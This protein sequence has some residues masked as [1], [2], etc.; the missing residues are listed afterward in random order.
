[1]T[2]Y[3]KS[4]PNWN[5]SQGPRIFP[6]LNPSEDLAYILGVLKG[7]GYVTKNGYQYNVCLQ[8][9]S[10][11]FVSSFE[12]SL[13]NIGLHPCKIYHDRRGIYHSVACSLQFVEFYKNLSMSRLKELIAGY[14]SHFIK[15][16]YESEGTLFIRGQTANFELNIANSNLELLKIVSRYLFYKNIRNSI[17]KRGKTINDLQMYR[18]RV[19]TNDI[20]KFL[21]MINPCIKYLYLNKIVKDY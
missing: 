14:H 18:L 12:T 9:I 4:H 20:P 8:S 16:L 6:D 19:Y 15:G 3:A 11:N 1:M 2:E 10:K 21:D 5:R 7:D 13:K 17:G